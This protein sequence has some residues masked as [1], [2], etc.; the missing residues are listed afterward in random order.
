[1]A[2]QHI[3]AAGDTI[4]RIAARY[5]WNATTFSDSLHELG[6]P[7]DLLAVERILA[8]RLVK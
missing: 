5:G 4:F 7:K 1:M 6:S 3:V 2:I 8:G